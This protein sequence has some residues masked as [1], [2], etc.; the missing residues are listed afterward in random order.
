M[1]RF[2]FTT[3]RRFVDDVY[4]MYMRFSRRFSRRHFGGERTL[5]IGECTCMNFSGEPAGNL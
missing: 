5:F 2:L 1:V 4:T 3:K